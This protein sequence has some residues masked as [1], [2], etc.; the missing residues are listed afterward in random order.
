MQQKKRKKCLKKVNIIQEYNE[1][2]KFIREYYNINSNINILNIFIFDFN[3]FMAFQFKEIMKKL[4]LLLGLVLLSNIVVAEEQ[5]DKVPITYQQLKYEISRPCRVTQDFTNNY[6]LSRK[7]KAIIGMSVSLSA[8]TTTE[9]FNI[10][11]NYKARRTAFFIGAGIATATT[12][13]LMFKN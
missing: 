8:F 1:N 6:G 7:Q 4:I 5:N 3:I 2:T 11:G 13:Y 10:I 9:Y 12:L